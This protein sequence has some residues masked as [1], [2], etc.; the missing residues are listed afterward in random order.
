MG[1]A[2]KV[3]DVFAGQRLRESSNS[4]E[5]HAEGRCPTR[6]KD[7]RELLQ[8]SKRNKEK[9]RNCNSIRWFGPSTHQNG[10]QQ[11]STIFQSYT[12][13]NWNGRSNDTAQ[14]QHQ[15]Q[16][17]KKIRLPRA[18]IRPLVDPDKARSACRR[19]SLSSNFPL[20]SSS[21][22]CFFDLSLFGPKMRFSPFVAVRFI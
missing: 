14:K 1:E 2:L 9:E 7:R 15:W 21:F 20:C 13:L 16:K 5:E 10:V 17:T 4:E 19:A 8:P 22:A 11:R 3:P 12:T 18:S 6:R